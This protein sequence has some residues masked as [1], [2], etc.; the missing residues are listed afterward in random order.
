VQDL[1]TK[2]LLLLAANDGLPQV[3]SNFME[4]YIHAWKKDEENCKL[5][6][7]KPSISPEGKIYAKISGSEI[8]EN[9]DR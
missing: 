9:I 3:R 5:T 2:K 1:L 4:G 8:N 7:F 6:H